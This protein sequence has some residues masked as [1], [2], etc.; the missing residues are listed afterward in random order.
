MQLLGSAERL[1]NYCC[2]LSDELPPIEGGQLRSRLPSTKLSVQEYAVH[3]LPL[4]WEAVSVDRIW[5]K[6]CAKFPRREQLLDCVRYI[7]D[8][9]LDV[10]QVL[11]GPI[12]AVVDGLGADPGGSRG[13]RSTL[14][15]ALKKPSPGALITTLLELPVS[16]DLDALLE[17]LKGDSGASGGA[18]LPLPVLYLRLD[19]EHSGGGARLGRAALLT[20]AYRSVPLSL[21]GE[22]QGGAPPIV[23]SG[24]ALWRLVD[25]LYRTLQ[26]QGRVSQLKEITLLIQAGARLVLKG[27]EGER[28][29]RRHVQG[30]PLRERVRGI[31]WWPEVSEGPGGVPRR[32]SGC[33]GPAQVSCWSEHGRGGNARLVIDREGIEAALEVLDNPGSAVVFCTR[34]LWEADSEMPRRICETHCLHAL[35]VVLWEGESDELEKRLFGSARERTLSDLLGRVH[36]AYQGDW[37]PPIL[38]TDARLHPDNAIQPE[39]PR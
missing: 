2:G 22:E 12:R 28:V 25:A 32:V 19:P 21:P 9:R 3:A 16:A 29:K 31:G 13:P 26:K 27:W 23:R 39:V 34:R 8:R 18:G 14:E 1:H 11:D 17:R 33:E 20:G 36:E 24:Q 7:I 30:A 38:W 37:C 6:L 35:T 10:V 5:E 15:E 4:L